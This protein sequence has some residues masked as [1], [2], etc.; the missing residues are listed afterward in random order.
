MPPTVSMSPDGTLEALAFSM[1]TSPDAMT[2]TRL[3]T[4]AMPVASSI[5]NLAETVPPFAGAV[6]ALGAGYAAEP[7]LDTGFVIYRDT[8]TGFYHAV[9]FPYS[10]GNPTFLAPDTIN[11]PSGLDPAG[12]G[13]AACKG[14]SWYVSLTEENG[15]IRTFRWT[16]NLAAIPVELTSIKAPLVAILNAAPG[17]TPTLLSSNGMSMTVYDENGTELYS[18]PAGSLRFVHERWDAAAGAWMAV[19]C[20]TIFI[21]SEKNDNGTLRT[22]VFEIPVSELSSLRS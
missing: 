6:S 22:E 11:V 3:F 4:D 7:G 18:F 15:A 16:N 8:T 2:A 13:F 10:S 14:N 17:G 19:F 9:E 12:V 21:R 5:I 20:R 1:K